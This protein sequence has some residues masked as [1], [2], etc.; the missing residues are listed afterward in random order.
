MPSEEWTT[1]RIVLGLI[2]TFVYKDE[3][4]PYVAYRPVSLSANLK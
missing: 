1:Y 2:L 4:R 3:L